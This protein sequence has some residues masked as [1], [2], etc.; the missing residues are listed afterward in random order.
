MFVNYFSAEEITKS[1]LSNDDT[2]NE[3]T[4]TQSNG[5]TGEW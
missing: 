1:T 4:T 3:E 5:D 2:Q